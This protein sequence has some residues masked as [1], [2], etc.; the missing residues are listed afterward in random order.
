ML[1]THPD[2]LVADETCD[3][4]D[5][6]CD[7]IVDEDFTAAMGLADVGLGEAC[8]V[9]ACAGGVYECDD[10]GAGTRCDSTAGGSKAA[11]ALETCDGADNDCDGE[12]DEDFDADG[13]AVGASCDHVDCGPGIAV[14]AVGG[15]TAI[16]DSILT[17]TDTDGD[18]TSDCADDDDDGDGT[19]DSEDCEP[20]DGA[21]HPAATEVCNGLDDDCNTEIDENGASGEACGE[22]ACANGKVICWEGAPTC[23]STVEGHVDYAVSGET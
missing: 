1:V 12:P 23:S 16:C 2:S 3:G 17:N 19:V 6:D 11:D 8:G 14:C 22:G 4:L 21:I 7:E 10:A 20:L 18:G 15:A 13:S 9:G 5:E